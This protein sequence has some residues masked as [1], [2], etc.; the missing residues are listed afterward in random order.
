MGRP[1]ITRPIRVD[2]EFGYVPLTRGYEAIIDVADIPLVE[3]HNW[4]ASIKKNGD[5]YA[6]SAIRSGDRFVHVGMHRYLLGTNAP[7][8]DHVNGDRLDNRRSNLRS[9]SNLENAQNKTVQR[10]SSVGL[11]GVMR[12]GDGFRSMITVNGVRHHLG[13]F[14]T[15]EEAAAAYVEKAQILRG[16]FASR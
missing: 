12:Y 7:S 8:V 16:E 4:H 2:G 10:N 5:V 1:K 15:K 13:C 14:S 3:I 11:R 6:A 9:C